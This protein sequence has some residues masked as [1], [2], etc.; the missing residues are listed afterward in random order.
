MAQ[1]SFS[2]CTKAQAESAKAILRAQ[3]FRIG[4]QTLGQLVEHTPEVLELLI[5]R[6]SK[7]CKDLESHMMGAYVRVLKAT[8]EL[9]SVL[10][11]RNSADFVSADDASDALVPASSKTRSPFQS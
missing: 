8:E 1:S 11:K 2:Y 4:Q 6:N 5:P 9:Q 7:R 10:T 3:Q